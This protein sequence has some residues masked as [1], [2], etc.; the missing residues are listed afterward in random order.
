MKDIVKN[1]ITLMQFIFIIH[2]VQM[3]TAILQIASQVAEK[4]G[5]DGWI[6][7]IIGGLLSMSASVIMILVMKHYPDGT[8]IDL[9][10]HYFGKWIGKL[11]TIIFILISG[12][13]AIFILNRSFLFLS[14]LVFPEGQVNILIVLGLIP[15]YII[16][17]NHFKIIGRYCELVTFLTIWIMLLFFFPLKEASFLRLLPILKEGW[18]PVFRGVNSSLLSFSGIMVILFLYPYL[19]KKEYA[20]RGVVIA[21][22]LTLFSLVFSTICIFLVFSPDEI[23]QFNTPMVTYLKIIEFQFLER[24]EIIVLSLYFFVMSTSWI[25]MMFLTAFCTTI[26][27]NKKDHKKYLLWF[28]IMIGIFILVFPP[29]FPQNDRHL[30]AMKMPIIGL[31]YIF[32]VVLLIL[33]WIRRLF[34]RGTKKNEL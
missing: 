23:V 34:Q 29:N 20:L 8:I 9:I 28:L 14:A 3:G 6:S 11:V 2:Q 21:N 33:L 5:S 10:S 7:I 13:L 31:E 26:L 22:T 12:S 18:E 17:R 27:L 30:Q 32:P 24:V 25:P 4:A 15:T 16:T 19:Q 1:E